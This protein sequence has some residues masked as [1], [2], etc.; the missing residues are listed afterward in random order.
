MRRGSE[1]FASVCPL[2]TLLVRNWW[3]IQAEIFSPIGH[4]FFFFLKN[5]FEI[6]I[7]NFLKVA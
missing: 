5:V 3:T 2:P 6:I 1:P 4:N 7:D